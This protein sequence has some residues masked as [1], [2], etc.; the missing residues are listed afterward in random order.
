M[1]RY[2]AVYLLIIN[3]ITLFA[4]GMDKHRARQGLWRVKENTLLLLAVIGGSAGA[5]LG[6]YGFRHKTKHK[7]FT[8]LVPVFLVCHVAL[9]VYFFMEFYN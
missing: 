2:L 9:M 7:K 3:L 8:V 1:F 4:Y 6:I 5:L